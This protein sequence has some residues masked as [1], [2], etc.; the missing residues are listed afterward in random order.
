MTLDQLT[1]FFG[2]AS[3]ISIAMLSIIFIL[4]LVFN[5][6]ILILHSQLF[7][8]AEDELNMIYLKYL[9][10]YKMLMVIFF[11]VPYLALNVM[12]W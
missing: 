9:A 2:W 7:N 11:I 8:V 10:Q 12:V 1:T 3:C 6:S 4:L 5:K